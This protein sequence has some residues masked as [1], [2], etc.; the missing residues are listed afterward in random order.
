MDGPQDISCAQLLG[1]FCGLQCLT[2]DHELNAVWGCCTWQR[3]CPYLFRPDGFG[4]STDVQ[5]FE[6]FSHNCKKECRAVS[7]TKQSLGPNVWLNLTRKLLRDFTVQRIL[8]VL[9]NPQR[10]TLF[11]F[12]QV[13]QVLGNLKPD[14]QQADL[15]RTF[16]LIT[17]QSKEGTMHEIEH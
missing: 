7:A 8:K 11:L 15:F 1:Y 16:A 5:V 6:S 3:S 4:R 10:S 12:A 14:M 17:N 9:Y 2:H 13:S